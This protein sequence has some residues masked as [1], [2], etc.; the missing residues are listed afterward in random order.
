[1][2]PGSSPGRHP[3]RGTFLRTN[4]EATGSDPATHIA[5]ELF[6]SSALESERAQGMPGEGL[7]NGPPA[8]RKAGG[9]HHRFSLIIRHSLRDGLRLIR[10]LPRDRLSCP[11]RPRARQ[12][13]ATL[14]SAPGCQDHTTSPSARYAIV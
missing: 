5:P 3:T 10:D 6:E 14:A 1:M 7:T 9:S 2:G 12:S 13:I 11:C 8:E 4:S